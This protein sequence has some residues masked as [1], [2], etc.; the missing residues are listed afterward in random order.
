MAEYEGVDALLAAITDEPLPE[1]AQDDAEFMAEHGSAMADVALLRE[2][3]GVIGDALAEPA[4]RKEAAKPAPTPARAPR[5]RARRA[6]PIALGTFAAAAVAAMVLGM[7]WL[8]SQNGIGVGAADSSSGE[9]A[10][11]NNAQSDQRSALSTPGYLACARLVVEGT[12]AQVEPGPDASQ[13]RITLDVSRYYKPEKGKDQV[14]LVVDLDIVPRLQKG[15]HVLVGIPA[16]AASAGTWI[17]G[18]ENIARERAWIVSALP[19][20]NTLECTDR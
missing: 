4:E 13:D 10:A 3:L 9:K 19:D 16:G 20:A 7:G 6:L 1:G 8:I 15:D 12:V 18:E 5:R 11:D 14:I 17:K 2:R